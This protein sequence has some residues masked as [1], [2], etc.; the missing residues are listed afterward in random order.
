MLHRPAR[1]RPTGVAGVRDPEFA[2]GAVRRVLDERDV[3]LGA[4]LDEAVKGVGHTV[5][6]VER[7]Q[8]A[9]EHVGE[10][11]NLH[12]DVGGADGEV[13]NAVRV[14][15]HVARLG[16]AQRAGACDG[17]ESAGACSIRRML[18]S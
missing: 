3:A 2:L 6:P 14:Q 18:A 11:L 12:L 5:H 15:C 1:H 17:E 10:K 7:F 9:P 8:L 16:H 13:M 4:Q